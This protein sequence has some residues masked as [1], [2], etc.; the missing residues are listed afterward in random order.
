[1]SLLEYIANWKGATLSILSRSEFEKER[2]IDWTENEIISL[3]EKIK[4]HWDEEKIEINKK[5]KKI[6]M[7]SS[8][9][10]DYFETQISE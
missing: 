9:F 5:P 3:F 1:M 4:S 10:E 2:L 8:I 6:I 7:G